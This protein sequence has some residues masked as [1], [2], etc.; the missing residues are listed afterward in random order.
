MCVD[1]LT[2]KTFHINM[3][4]HEAIEIQLSEKKKIPNKIKR[5]KYKVDE[6]LDR[7]EHETNWDFQNAAVNDYRRRMVPFYLLGDE[8]N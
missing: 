4:T 7:K 3:G 1:P 5:E 2:A 8:S 6:L